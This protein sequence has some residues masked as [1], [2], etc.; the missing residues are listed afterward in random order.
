[1]RLIP[2]K[3]KGL[4]VALC[5][6][7]LAFT[8]AANVLNLRGRWQVTA[9]ADPSFHGIMLIDAE[10]R[11]AWDGAWSR[12][13]GSTEKA[14]GWRGYVRVDGPTPEIILTT[15]AGLVAH[16]HCSFQSND[17]LHC[18]HFLSDGRLGVPMVF[19]RVGEGPVSLMPAAR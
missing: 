5:A 13:N 14:T 15:G 8:T 2:I 10:G 19:T 3:K 12:P 4:A 16:A 17:V 1:V 18:T 11:V 6:V 7:V 9:P